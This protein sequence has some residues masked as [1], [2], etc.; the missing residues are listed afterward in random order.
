[1]KK[2]IAILPGIL[3]LSGAISC[4]KTETPQNAPTPTIAKAGDYKRGDFV[5]SLTNLRKITQAR[6]VSGGSELVPSHLYVRFRPTNQ[7]HID[8]IKSNRIPT[9][10]YPLATDSLDVS[11][12]DY[13][14]LYTFLSIKKSLPNCPY[15]I[16]DTVMMLKPES[17]GSAAAFVAAG[18]TDRIP[19]GESSAT[20][21]RSINH[22][23]EQMPCDQWSDPEP[24]GGQQYEVE[25]PIDCL[26]CGCGGGG[27]PPVDPPNPP[28][29]QTPPGPADPLTAPFTVTYNSCSMNTDDNYPSG[30]IRVQ[31]T[32]W[33]ANAYE[34]VADVRIEILG[35][36]G[37]RVVAQT[38]RYGCFKATGA[39][40]GYKIPRPFAPP[41]LL[42][43]IQNVIFESGRKEIR[44]VNKAII[45]QYTKPLLHVAGNISNRM[46]SAHVTYDKSTG[47]GP[48]DNDTKYFVAATVNNALYDYDEYATQDGIDKPRQGIK[49]MV[50]NFASDGAAPMLS[51]LGNSGFT[52]A[53]LNQYFTSIL[54]GSGGL[55]GPLIAQVPDI[56]Y[57][58]S[59]GA[60][61]FFSDQIKEVAYHEFAHASHFQRTSHSI[62]RANIEFVSNS[63]GYGNAG[64]PGVETTDLI[65]MWGYFM[66][67]EYTHRRYGPN[68]HSSLNAFASP[69]TATF[70][71]SFYAWNE[72]GANFFSLFEAGNHIAAG[73]LHDIRD[74]NQV[75]QAAGLGEHASVTTEAISGYSI[76]TI[77]NYLDGSTPT[78]ASLI[79][80][81][82]NSLPAGATNTVA[83]YDLLASYYGY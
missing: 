53:T 14:Q 5:Y 75:N 30:R 21:V 28:D 43:V 44:G 41:S 49:I 71:N 42:P 37:Q 57:G 82:R 66:G 11:N 46:N 12:P 55:A 25:A 73:F 48:D 67:R 65:E 9:Y 3:M 51:V 6:S 61:R 76:A 58:Y 10:P 18:K 38:N 63:G 22:E 15:E 7:A 62:W 56:L 81:L 80:K 23:L 20:V 29:P 35:P 79:G 39:I 8:A 50:T 33:G 59:W 34:G 32:Q 27:N 68:A 1:M 74:N 78:A 26:D 70:A 31:E 45:D 77:F 19:I 40:R 36:N 13:S 52:G 47:T 24:G 69:A 2:L 72:N 60:G 64:D 4:K 83:N 16:L 54:W 17:P